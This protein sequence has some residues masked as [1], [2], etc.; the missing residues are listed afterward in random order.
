MHKDFASNVPQYSSSPTSIKRRQSER[1]ENLKYAPISNAGSII[2]SNNNNSSKSNKNKSN[3]NNNNGS[4]NT[5]SNYLTPENKLYSGGY[6]R[7]NQSVDMNNKNYTPHSTNTQKAQQSRID[8]DFDN[9]Y[10]S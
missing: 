5:G 3:F 6:Q 10:F 4:S 2:I 9:V 8:Y 7:K 1:F